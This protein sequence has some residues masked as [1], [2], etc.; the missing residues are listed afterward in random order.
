MDLHTDPAYSLIKLLKKMEQQGI[1]QDDPVRQRMFAD[2]LNRQAR[3]KA[4]P[5]QGIF[6]LTPRCNFDCKMCY[7]HLEEEQMKHAKE[8]PGNVWISL[9]DEAVKNGMMKAQLT[10]G[11]AM[12]HP[13]FDRIYLHLYNKGI[14]ISLLSN[15]FLLNRER[16]EFLKKY[17]PKSLQVS[18]YGSDN[19]SYRRL[20]GRA[21]FDRVKENIL[22]AK[23]IGTNFV[24]A[25]TPNKYFPLEEVERALQFA[26]KEKIR[27]Q[28]NKDL[29]DPYEE[30]GRDLTGLEFSEEDYFHVR[31]MLCEFNDVK[32]QTFT[33]E[34]PDPV[35][36]A[37]PGKGVACAAGRSLF[38]VNWRGEMR[39]CLDLPFK[40]YPLEEGFQKAWEYVHERA[41]NY[42][43]P[44]ECLS[45]AYNGIC[46]VCPVIHAKGAEPGHADKRICGRTLR[47]VRAGLVKLEE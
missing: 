27:I 12:L 22:L 13:D 19:A 14:W 38:A 37:N 30:T 31:H 26:K 33:G 40:A 5:Q 7:V 45:C 8:L 20:T 36:T 35:W 10:G 47:L 6:E 46:T 17:P 25:V 21:V 39:A 29:V 42:P 2:M 41:V 34:L 3:S 23:E 11:E 18:L 4:V 44:G 28:I 24:L 15:G 9:M 1:D 43:F 16:V 32:V